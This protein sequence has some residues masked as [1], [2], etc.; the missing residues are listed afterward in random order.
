MSSIEFSPIQEKVIKERGKNILVSA[1]AGSGKTTVLVERIIRRINDPVNPTDIDRLLILTYTNAAAG[2]MKERIAAA[3]RK[4]IELRPEDEHLRR[5]SVLIYNAQITTIH[6]FCLNLLKN[7]FAEIGIE[8]GFRI[9]DENEYAF[10]ASEVLDETVEELFSG[11]EIKYFDEF[12]DRFGSGDSV[13]KIKE[14]IADMHA[15]AEKA[16]FFEDYLDERM[17]DY[18]Y[19]D[20]R[21]LEE[22]DW[23]KSFISGVVQE[24][25]KA[26]GLIAANLELCEYTPEYLANAEADAAVVSLFS[27]CNSYEK[28]FDAY[29]EFALIGWTTLSRKSGECEEERELFKQNRKDIKKII[30]GYK[31]VFSTEISELCRKME[32]TCHAVEALAD[33]T[34]LYHCK[35]EESKRERKII[36]FSDMEHLSLRILLKKEGDTY[37]ATDVAKDYR[38]IYDEI[39][40]DEY[41]DSNYIQELLLRSISGE[42]DGI[43]NRFMVGDIKQSIYRFR[44][45]NPELFI[46]K[47]ESYPEDGDKCIRIDLSDNFRSRRE[48]LSGVNAIFERVM[49]KDMGG[50]D[51]DDAAALHYGS[52]KYKESPCDNRTELLVLLKDAESDLNKNEQEGML[53]S[54]RIKHLIDENVIQDKDT[55]E[56]R[57][58]EYKDIVILIRSGDDVAASYKRMLESENIPCYITT[59]KGYFD[60]M[61]V[62]TV[63]NYLSVIDNPNNDIEMY[64]SLLSV[65][66]R[67]TENEIALMRI[68][69]KGKLIN[70][71]KYVDSTEMT[72]IVKALPGVSDTCVS[73]LKNKAK[74]FLNQTSGYRSLVTYTPI[75]ELIQMIY[76]DTCYVEY[77]SSLP[78]GEQ[79]KANTLMLL[80]KAENYEA[81]GFRGLFH[82][83][84]YIDAIRKYNSEDG[85]AVVLDENA[86]VVRIMTMHKSKG[87]EFPIC[88][89]AGLA[90]QFNRAD[91][92]GDMVFHSDYGVG[93]DYIDSSKRTKEPDLRKKFIHDCIIRDANSEE[94]RVLYVALTRAKEKLIM[95][96]LTDDEDNPL[97]PGQNSMIGFIAS[98]EGGDD[99]SGNI[100]F[101]MY[102]SS[103]ILSEDIKEAMDLRERRA[104]YIELT[105]KKADVL[106]IL[107]NIHREYSHKELEGLYTK[108]TVSELKMASI[109]EQLLEDS[110]EQGSVSL[111]HSDDKTE[112]VPR[113]CK[114]QSDDVSGAARGSAYHRVMELYDFA[115]EESLDEQLDMRVLEGSLTRDEISLVNREKV[116]RFISCELGK[117]MQSAS[118][119]SLLYKEQP[120]VL[121]ISADR[122]EKKFPENELVLIQGII[123]VFFY[124]GDEIV[125]MDYKT[126]RVSEANEL[127]RRYKTQL[128]Y[129]E[130]ALTRITGKRV[131]ERIIYSFALECEITL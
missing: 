40:I 74:R 47:Y 66:G 86:N 69:K 31:E 38:T 62:S 11:T 127:I 121:G 22:S 39:M 111:F 17:L 45:A 104:E 30:D 97:K 123:D 41:Q 98:A 116:E 18:S 59:K 4:E 21:S 13:R 114:T 129:Y 75:H 76:N 88:I 102:D 95:T 103:Y 109:N 81:N 49:S 79:K 56:F 37:V 118:K 5:Q 60:S 24:F 14:A 113:F 105:T 83:V 36:T 16:P 87:L 19:E 101:K 91:S 108:T 117:R 73:E 89:V 93:L 61:E 125:L 115:S 42:D 92:T 106:D 63:T 110:Q 96:S 82:F 15:E 94:L 72:E 9:V 99:W 26:A 20:I 32:S 85:D 90:K 33:A 84:R 112:I 34:R 48:V 122:L 8:P 70:C 51:Y 126:D 64:G 80:R 57:P 131:K 78:L 67:F 68:L 27:D 23:M 28:I 25:E 71:L 100:D 46:Q 119:L 2:E 29:R 3:I 43:F 50:V 7:N 12:T 52:V 1:A 58:C 55:G 10:L 120:F 35:L 65:F 128:D 124:E 54:K 44:N 6:S 130:E 77:V 107:E 53:I